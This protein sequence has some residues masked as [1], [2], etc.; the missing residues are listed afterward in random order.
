MNKP[1]RNHIVDLR[2]IEQVIKNAGI[3]TFL[4]DKQTYPK[5]FKYS[6]ICFVTTGSVPALHKILEK[7]RIIYSPKKKYADNGSIKIIGPKRKSIVYVDTLSSIKHSEIGKELLCALEENWAVEWLWSMKDTGL[8]KEFF[9]EL[10][11]TIVLEGGQHHSETVFEHLLGSLKAAN[12]YPTKLKLATLLHDIVKPATYKNYKNEKGHVLSSFHK[13][14]VVG[15][16]IAF[17]MCRRLSIPPDVTKYVVKLI[18]HHM[19]YFHDSSSEKTIKKW[20]YKLGR[21][22]WKDVIYLRIAD[23]KGNKSNIDKP[24]MTKELKNLIEKIE[25]IITNTSAVFKEDLQICKEDIK[26]ITSANPD[27]VLTNLIGLVNQ[28]T[29]RNNPDWLID[30]VAKVY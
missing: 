18:R 5:A 22:D 26:T 25:D 6:A 3:K 27:T 15:A 17:N 16:T 14:E 11:D 2:L 30:Y 7:E 9:P 23:R 29:T 19:F 8:L 1:I 24:A 10:N 4:I 12:R 28:N 13:H 21:E 20:L